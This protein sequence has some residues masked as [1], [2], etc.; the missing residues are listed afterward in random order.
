MVRRS[1]SDYV[2]LPV[3]GRVDAAAE[4]SRQGTVLQ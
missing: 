3:P 1:L 4:L 2:A